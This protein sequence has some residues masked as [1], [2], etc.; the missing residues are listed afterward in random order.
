MTCDDIISAACR[1][2]GVAQ[3]DLLGRGRSWPLVHY[4]MV[5]I[6]VC[7]EM[8]GLSYPAIGRAFGRDH[9]TCLSADQRVKETAG[10][11]ELAAVLIAKINEEQVPFAPWVW[12]YP[13]HRTRMNG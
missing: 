11:N 1:T 2:F 13:F 5:A 10:L 3:S 12:R 4:R 6:S 9:T 7:A 8:T